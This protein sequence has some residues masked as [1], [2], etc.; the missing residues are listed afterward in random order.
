MFG[1]HKFIVPALF[2]ASALLAACSDQRAVAPKPVPE[3]GFITVTPRDVPQVSSFVAQTESSRQVEIVAR[4]AGFLD[5]IAYTEGSFVKEGQVLFQIDPKPFKA[6]LDA[7][8]GELAAQQARLTTLTVTLKRVKN[9]PPLEH[10]ASARS[11]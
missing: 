3:V 8:Q 6:Q 9:L 4:V 5:R 11:T 1:P 7:A 10:V 2:A